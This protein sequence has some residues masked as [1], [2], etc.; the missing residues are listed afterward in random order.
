MPV[1]EDLLYDR[2]P[3]LHFDLFQPPFE[4]NRPLLEHETLAVA[5]QL[6]QI[7]DLG[8]HAQRRTAPGQVA[9]EADEQA[10]TTR[11]AQSA[12]IDL[13]GRKV[14]FVEEGWR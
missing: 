5:G 1:R 11:D 6:L 10:G 13:S 8:I 3:P 7:H 9:I 4:W 2:R 12:R 14:E